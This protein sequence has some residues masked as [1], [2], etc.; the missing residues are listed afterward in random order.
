MRILLVDDHALF[1]RSLE[2]V[3]A[4]FPEIERF[5]SVKSLAELERSLLQ[6]RPDILLMDINLESFLRKTGS[7]WPKPFC[8]DFPTRRSSS[9]PATIFPFTVKRPKK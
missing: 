8:S 7:F 1:A 4:D 9:C 3:L 5:S 2:I 6:E